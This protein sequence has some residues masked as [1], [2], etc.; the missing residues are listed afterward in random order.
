MKIDDG[1][2]GGM[3]KFKK[4]SWIFREF[5]KKSG[6]TQEI[7]GESRLNILNIGY[8]QHWDTIFISRKTQYEAFKPNNQ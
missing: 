3:P 7:Q 8:A 5:N 2:S 1:I 6:K 4:E